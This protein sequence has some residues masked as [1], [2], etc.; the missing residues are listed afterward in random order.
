MKKRYDRI[1]MK[2]NDLSLM[3]YQVGKTYEKAIKN[4]PDDALKDFF[5]KKGVERSNFGELLQ[6]EITK[7]EGNNEGSLMLD[8]RNHLIKMN[9]KNLLHF[10]NEKELFTAV[11][12]I[13]LLSIEKYNEL[14]MEIHLP[15]SL[16]KLLI[17]ERDY[18]QSSLGLI[19]R[20]EA[21]FA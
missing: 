14:L 17:K 4:V 15:L 8:R 2:L 9:F 7:L 3:N 1:F 5:R 11:H 10:E 13:M 6:R 21:V 20:K 18:I 19:K 16:C 12:K